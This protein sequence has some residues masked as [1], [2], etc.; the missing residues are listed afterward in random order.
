MDVEMPGHWGTLDDSSQKSAP[1]DDQED[2]QKEIAQWSLTWFA[3]PCA[4]KAIF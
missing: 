4:N 2:G 3:K 1:N